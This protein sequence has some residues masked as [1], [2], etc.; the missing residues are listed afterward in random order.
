MV[1]DRGKMTARSQSSR[2]LMSFVF[3]EWKE[4]LGSP[5]WGVGAAE[6]HD[7]VVDH[8]ISALILEIKQL[9]SLIEDIRK[10]E[11]GDGEV[12]EEEL[13]DDN[14]KE[15]NPGLEDSLTL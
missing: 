12:L 7:M 5:R 2:L 1:I 3:L 8:V 9:D 13:A 6:T 15:E 11:M 4:Q 10:E 14:V